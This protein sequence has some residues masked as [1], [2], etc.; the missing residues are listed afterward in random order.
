MIAGVLIGL[1]VMA[2]PVDNVDPAG[3]I[4]IER[5]DGSDW[6]VVEPDIFGFGAESGDRLD[7]RFPGS[8]GIEEA[9]FQ[10]LCDDWGCEQLVWSTAFD[11][12]GEWIAENIDF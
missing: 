11:P 7:V 2:G 12:N 8:D 5:T 3:V 4:R 6:I 10:E 1:A 9:K